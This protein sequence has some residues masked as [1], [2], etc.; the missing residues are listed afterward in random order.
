MYTLRAVLVSCSVFFLVYLAASLAMGC[1][2][3]PKLLARWTQLRAYLRPANLIYSIRISPLVLAA[4]AVAGFT[5]P[6]FLRFEPLVSDESA[7]GLPVVLTAGLLSIVAVGGWR[8]W[9]AYAHT[10]RWVDRCVRS[11]TT[12]P[13]AGNIAVVSSPEA[14][15]VAMAGLCKSTI[16][17]SAEAHAALSKPELRCAVAHELAHAGAGD[18]L[19]KLLLH[20]CAFPGLAALERAWMDAAEFSADAA[21]VKSDADAVEL[22]S[23]LVKVSR[24]RGSALPAIASGLAEGHSGLLAARVER[25]IHR[26]IHRDK[27]AGMRSAWNAALSACSCA[28]ILAILFNYEALLRAAH[29]CTEL[30]VR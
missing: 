30:L 19:K 24:L 12:H 15:P 6:A 21:A 10:Q 23:A 11:S 16:L 18:N 3:R 22:A 20:L 7:G 29:E 5:V 9:S 28:V 14:A 4:I 2:C 13:V 8:A 27:P 26:E 1:V 17:I 25:L